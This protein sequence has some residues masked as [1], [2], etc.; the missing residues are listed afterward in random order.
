MTVS[1]V[2]LEIFESGFFY[3]FLHEILKALV[4]KSQ[5]RPPSPL[6]GFS[7]VLAH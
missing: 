1:M 7:L 5:N 4:L 3:W 2:F 6:S